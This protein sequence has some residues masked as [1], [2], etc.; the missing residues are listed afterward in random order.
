MS[1]ELRGILDTIDRYLAGA[2]GQG[3]EQ[4]RELWSVLSALRGP[5]E[6]N[7]RDYKGCTTSVLRAAAFP[8]TAKDSNY[9]G[10]RVYASMVTDG[11]ETKRKRK[12]IDLFFPG[13]FLQ[14]AWEAFEALGLTW[15]R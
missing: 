2:D 3:R 9:L 4:S 1:P 11:R 8:L 13:H 10:G 6:E 12:S 15:T 14:H 7:K 5:D